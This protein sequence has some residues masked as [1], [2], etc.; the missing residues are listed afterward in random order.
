V[1][2]INIRCS[3]K[4]SL[5]CTDIDKAAISIWFILARPSSDISILN[6]YFNLKIERK[7]V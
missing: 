4:V 3:S 5:T 7:W 1:A 2:N 6:I